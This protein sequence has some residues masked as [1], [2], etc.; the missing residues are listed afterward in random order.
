[1]R[2]HHAVGNV[3][4]DAY[5]VPSEA[6]PEAVTVAADC[7]A[8]ISGENADA[9]EAV[10]VEEAA[11]ERGIAD[12][13]REQADALVANKPGPKDPHARQKKA[14]KAL[15]EARSRIPALE[16]AI[17][18]AGDELARAIDAH[19]AEW[20][21]R[22]HGSIIEQHADLLD[23]LHRTRAAERRLEETVGAHEW[24]ARWKMLTHPSGL[25]LVDNGQFVANSMRFRVD[26]H[27][28]QP[29]SGDQVSEV[30]AAVDR[31]YRQVF[32]VAPV[33]EEEQAGGEAA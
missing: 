21:S 15:A 12:D 33:S 16:Q 1:M 29:G 32:E 10:G 27:A 2:H 19:A 6:Q 30:L 8:R 5:A 17:D 22:L 23:L 18:L 25:V 11:V 7:F 9:R 28:I 20:R 24:L 31:F 13:N 3:I 14:E 4:D 26:A